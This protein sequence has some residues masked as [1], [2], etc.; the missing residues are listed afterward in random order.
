MRIRAYRLRQSMEGIEITKGSDLLVFDFQDSK[1]SPGLSV[2][3]NPGISKHRNLFLFFKAIP[4]T[5]VARLPLK[6][7]TNRAEIAFM[8]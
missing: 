4:S 3:T 5:P 6:E 1:L 8:S 2:L 7:G